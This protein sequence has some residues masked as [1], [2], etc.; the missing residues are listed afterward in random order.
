MSGGKISKD[1]IDLVP[2]Y[3][4]SPIVQKAMGDLERILAKK[5]RENTVEQ[6]KAEGT[7]GNSK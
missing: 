4:E 3:K 6:T 2:H 5:Q 7:M 1:L